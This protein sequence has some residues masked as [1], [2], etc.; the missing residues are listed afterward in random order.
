MLLFII[1]FLWQGQLLLLL[2]R[3]R[4]SR[5]LSSLRGIS[6]YVLHYQLA[7][8]T[9]KRFVFHDLQPSAWFFKRFSH[10]WGLGLCR[11][12][13]TEKT[14]QEE[15]RNWFHGVEK[16]SFSWNP[17]PGGGRSPVCSLV[18]YALPICLQLNAVTNLLLWWTRSWKSWNSTDRWT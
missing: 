3:T 10:I 7:A 12:C 6:V 4:D 14:E 13:L 15:N 2:F 8:I 11:R 18:L 9:S 16:M 17:F 1:C 5:N